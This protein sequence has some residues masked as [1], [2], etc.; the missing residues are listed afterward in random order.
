MLLK[1]IPGDYW[2]KT[3]SFE[4]RQ[5]RVSWKWQR[6]SCVVIGPKEIVRTRKVRRVEETVN[7][8]LGRTYVILL[9]DFGPIINIDFNIIGACCSSHRLRCSFS[10]VWIWLFKFYVLVCPFAYRVLAHA[11]A[12]SCRIFCFQILGP[13]W[14]YGV[15]YRRLSCLW[16]TQDH[17]LTPSQISLCLKRTNNMNKLT[18]LRVVFFSFE[19]LIIS[20]LNME[21]SWQ[22]RIFCGRSASGFPEILKLASEGKFT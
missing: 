21:S 2:S 17:Q 1:Y 3:W 9:I 20:S 8:C 16:L 14:S 22:V 18:N 10:F 11:D 7:E 6:R 19:N 15:Y 5:S 13:F 12:F 4:K